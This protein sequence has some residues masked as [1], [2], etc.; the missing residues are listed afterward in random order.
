M[1][2][3]HATI[4]MAALAAMSQDGRLPG[5]HDASGR[6]PGGV[7]DYTGWS[8]LNTHLTFEEPP[9][10]GVIREGQTMWMGGGGGTYWVVD[11][12][13]HTVAVSFSQSFGGRGD[14]T[15]A[16]K[17]KKLVPSLSSL[18][19]DLLCSFHSV[20]VWTCSLRKLRCYILLIALCTSCRCFAFSHVLLFEGRFDFHGSCSG[21]RAA[22]GSL[23]AATY[24][25]K[26]GV[27]PPE[28]LRLGMLGVTGS[29]ANLRKVSKRWHF[30]C[31]CRFTVDLPV[32]WG[33]A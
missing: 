23:Q 16:A 32:I 15:D 33:R 7:W 14:S 26:V 17:D 4:T 21:R 22:A 24:E 19:V 5:W 6:S 31:S 18:Y 11:R 27:L 25:V 2:S 3:Y 1:P 12:N 10:A 8:L 20:M 9:K 28:V 30:A 13:H 29:T